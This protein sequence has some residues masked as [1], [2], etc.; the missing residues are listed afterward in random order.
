[1][2]DGGIRLIN[3]AQSF[4]PKP[5]AVIGFLVI[6]GLEC[7]IK[8]TKLFPHSTR[9]EKEGART[10]IDVAPEV[11]HRRKG[12]IS[13]TIAGTGSIPPD[14]ASGFLQFSV[15]QNDLSAN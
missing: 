8:A 7:S 6:R 13:A 4:F 3:H 5:Q 1:M 9:R 11:V 14:D 10:I 12:I 15:Q 2:H